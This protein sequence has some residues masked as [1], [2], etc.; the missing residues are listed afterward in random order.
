MESINAIVSSLLKSPVAIGL[1]LL[2]WIVFPNESL[3]ESWEL[4][5][6]NGIWDVEN[7]QFLSCH[8]THWSMDQ[9]FWD[10]IAFLVLG[11]I[12]ERRNRL[13]FV[14][15]VLISAATVSISTL[16]FCS[17]VTSYRG[18]S[19]IDS[20]LFV[21]AA[22]GIICDA[23]KTNRSLAIFGFLGLATF[24]AKTAY[25]FRFGSTLF[26]TD[27]SFRPLPLAHIIGALTA[28]G[29]SLIAA[30]V[31]RLGSRFL[32]PNLSLVQIPFSRMN[33]NVSC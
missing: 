9:L 29:V 24:L 16:V 14:T 23:W 17:Y 15:T 28:L 12:C 11:V 25:E 2:S 3:Q 5:W 21:L 33:P 8:F 1:F 20:A 31:A 32:K 27:E 13:Q 4:S 6:R 10:S 26:V 7:W 22:I 30:V 19:G 18:L